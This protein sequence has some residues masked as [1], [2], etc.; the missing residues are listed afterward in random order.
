MKLG[1]NSEM[2]KCVVGKR[3]TIGFFVRELESEHDYLLLK[4]ITDAVEENDVNLLIFRGKS[5]KS[6]FGQDYQ[7]N[8]AYNYANTEHLDALIVSSSPI[9]NHI[10]REEI[11]DFIN[12]FKSI[13]VVSIAAATQDVPSVFINNSKGLKDVLNH[14]IK[15]HGRRRIAFIKGPEQNSEAEERFNTYKEVLSENKIGFDPNLVSNGNFFADGGLKAIETLVE[16]RKVNFDALM[17]ANDEMALA[18]MKYLQNKGFNI[19]E[20][21]SIVGFDNVEGSRTSTPTLTTVRQPIYAKGR[22][23]VKMALDM[24]DGKKVENIFLDTEYLI[25]ES[26]GCKTEAL[27]NIDNAAISESINLVADTSVGQILNKLI[28]SEVAFQSYGKDKIDLIRVFVNDCYKLML[29]DYLGE[30]TFKYLLRSFKYILNIGKIDDSQEVAIQKLITALRNSVIAV[31]TDKEK[32][33][34]IEEFFQVLRVESMDIIIKEQS[35]SMNLHYYDVRC[36]RNI[37][38]YMVSNIYEKGEQLNSII[39]ELQSVGIKSCYVYL[40]DKEIVHKYGSKWSNIH[41]L[42]LAMAYDTEGNRII[43]VKNRVSWRDVIR[44]DILPQ[45]RRFQLMISPLFFM[46]EQLGLILCEFYSRDIYFFESLVVEMSCALKFSFLINE[47]QKI[48]TQLRDA[49]NKLEQYNKRLNNLS[50]TDELTGLYNRRGFLSL[51]KK[52]LQFA[53]DKGKNGALFFVDMDGLKKINDAYGHDEGDMAIKAAANILRKAF[54]N[55]DII[56]R[57]GGDEFTILAVADEGRGIVD[58]QD[59]INQVNEDYNKTSDKP[60]SISMSIGAVPFSNSDNANI[61]ELMNLADNL[62]YIRKREKKSKGV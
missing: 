43:D 30:D 15:Y 36:L 34:K 35:D 57:L 56:A 49:M 17:A 4:G 14:L 50:N 45:N 12:Q 53:R 27:H 3:K 62:L 47:R 16:E 21:I 23:A 41:K 11:S 25:R 13:P 60:Y 31:V 38:S 48:E 46:E 6:P 8:V 26:C 22:I 32:Q 33:Y 42:N 28:D 54:K 5:I 2:K 18:I 7:F 37:L 40:Y 44:K 1:R 59:T 39:S 24:V 55:E 29:N 58:I 10:S 9:F 52:S 51:A 19:P 20:D 61:E